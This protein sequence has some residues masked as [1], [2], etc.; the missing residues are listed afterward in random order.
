MDGGSVNDSNLI[1]KFLDKIKCSSETTENFLDE[2]ELDLK[3]ISVNNDDISDYIFKMN[4]EELERFSGSAEYI[5]DALL[6]RYKDVLNESS[7]ILDKSMTMIDNLLASVKPSNR[8]NDNEQIAIKYTKYF[9]ELAKNIEFSNGYQKC[10]QVMDAIKL[11]STIA[12]KLSQIDHRIENALDELNEKFSSQLK[13]FKVEIQNLTEES[14]ETFSREI[15]EIAQK[16]MDNLENKSKEFD[17]KIME[18]ERSSMTSVITVLGIFTAISFLVF[19]SLNLA[20]VTLTQFEFIS[21]IMITWSLLTFASLSILLFLLWGISRLINKEMF[22]K[23]NLFIYFVYIICIIV[24]LCGL[25]LKV[26]EID[27]KT[28]HHINLMM[29]NINC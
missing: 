23:K 15:H 19:G 24:F 10:K 4:E 9:N 26:Q 11:W 1:Y 7:N 5:L 25:Y 28:G 16:Q 17:S 2:L 20:Q 21:D 6:R 12:N 3:L 13:D 14:R 8:R 29:Q 27:L 18:S 22:D